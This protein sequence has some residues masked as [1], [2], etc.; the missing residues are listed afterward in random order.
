MSSFTNCFTYNF[1]LISVI[2]CILSNKQPKH[3]FHN[4]PSTRAAYSR[5]PLI[6]GIAYSTTEKKYNYVFKKQKERLIKTKQNSK[7]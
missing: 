7:K 2:Y 1:Q 5:A 3:L 6:E 4:W